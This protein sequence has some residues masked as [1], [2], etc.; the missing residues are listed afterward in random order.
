MNL[1]VKLDESTQTAAWRMTALACPMTVGPSVN[2][3]AANFSKLRINAFV[4]T[5][6]YTQG[7]ASTVRIRMNL[8]P[9]AEPVLPTPKQRNIM[10]QL[11]LWRHGTADVSRRIFLGFC[12]DG[13]L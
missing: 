4:P 3:A 12:I 6:R 2:S 8:K 7:S 13:T 10:T 11:C 5:R 1:L 9:L